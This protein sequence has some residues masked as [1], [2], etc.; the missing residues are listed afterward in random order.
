MPKTWKLRPQTRAFDI[1]MATMADFAE[2]C[3]KEG[4]TSNYFRW[5]NLM[6]EMRLREAASL[7]PG[8]NVGTGST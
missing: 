7:L 6:H 5:R 1:V 4:D 3:K 8:G 2:A